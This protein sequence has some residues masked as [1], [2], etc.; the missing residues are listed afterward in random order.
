MA[1]MS[2]E[3]MNPLNSIINFNE[4]LIE[5]TSNVL[6]QANQSVASAEDT[7]SL[8][9]EENESVHFSEESRDVVPLH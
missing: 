8:S 4:Y 6:R 5:W 2:H 7:Y 1:T 3:Q 9:Q